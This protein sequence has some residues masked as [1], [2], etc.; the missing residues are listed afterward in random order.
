M[1]INGGMVFTPQQFNLVPQQSMIKSQ[2]RQQ[3]GDTG[4]R[5]Q[6][7]VILNAADSDK[8]LNAIQSQII[9]GL[10]GETIDRQFHR[11]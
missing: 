1:T 10:I 8:A 2:R 6:A 3:L 4:K 9:E 5:D 11:S 7:D